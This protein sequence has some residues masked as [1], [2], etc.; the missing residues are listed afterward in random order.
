[1]WPRIS[2]VGWPVTLVSDGAALPTRKE[3]GAESTK[4]PEGPRLRMVTGTVPV[5]TNKDGGTEACKN[6]GFVTVVGV[7]EA[8][9][10]SQLPVVNLLMLPVKILPLKVMGSV[11]FVPCTLI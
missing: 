1:T 4:S 10:T 3:T 11:K 7:C 8:E 2:G 6:V 5:V 9:K